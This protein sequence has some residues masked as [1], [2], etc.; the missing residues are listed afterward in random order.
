VDGVVTSSYRY[1]TLEDVTARRDCSLRH[2][3]ADA[4]ENFFATF[5]GITLGDLIDRNAAGQDAGPVRVGMPTLPVPPHD[6]N[7][8]ADE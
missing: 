6:N 8:N 3:L 5:D 1:T 7:H 4:Q 2:L